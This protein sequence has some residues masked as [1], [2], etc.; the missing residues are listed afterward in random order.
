MEFPCKILDLRLKQR[1]IVLYTGY[2]RRIQ[3]RESK[4]LW[5][6]T[7]TLLTIAEYF[8][9]LSQCSSNNSNHIFDLFSSQT[10][11]L[12]L[13]QPD[14]DCSSLFPS[15]QSLISPSLFL[16]PPYQACFVLNVH[17]CLCWAS[18]PL[19][20]HLM[21]LVFL[22]LPHVLQSR[23]IFQA[24]SVL[25]QFSSKKWQSYIL[26]TLRNLCW[27]ISLWIHL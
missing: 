21:E 26:H 12:V 19:Q 2:F 15:P 20:F 1:E 5:N 23:G 25:L 13:G 9:Y 10:Q 16:S 14:S 7:K 11:V 3:Y 18:V 17:P 4:F 24:S 8:Q 22:Q 27:F 6:F